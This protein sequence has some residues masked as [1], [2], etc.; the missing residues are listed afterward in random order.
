MKKFILLFFGLGLMLAQETHAQ[1]PMSTIVKLQNDKEVIIRSIKKHERKR[2]AEKFDSRFENEQI[3]QVFYLAIQEFLKREDEQ[4]ELQFIDF[5]KKRFKTIGIINNE[6]EIQDIFK[7]L[8]ITNAIDDIFYDILSGLNKDHQKLGVLKLDKKNR[9]RSAKHSKL[10]QANNLKDLFSG[11]SEWP[12]ESS[13]CV[14][15]EFVFIKNSIKNK[16]GKDSDKKRHLKILLEKAYQEKVFD[17]ATFNKLEYLRTESFVTKRNYWLKDYFK[18]IFN[19]KNKMRPLKATYVV[20][21]IEDEEGY[22]TE[23][24]RRFSRMTRRQL[25]YKKYDET[26]IILLAQVLQ[27]ASRRM[28]VDPDTE[29]GKP[30]ITQ[31]FHTL[32]DAGTR[33]TY[34]E[35][36]ELDPQSQYNLARR[37]LRKDMT[38]LQMMDTFIGL[39]V[40]YEDL[41]MAAF[42]TGYITFEDLEF[43][44]KYDDLW[45]P[46]KSS[47]EKIIGFTFSVA[48][49]SSIFLPPPWNITATIAL[50]VIEGLILNTKRD[51]AENDNP[52]TFIE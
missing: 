27:K 11:F 5:I 37:L 44:V 30:V 23:R 7:M 28:G 39:K 26:Q 10:L 18:I 41:V 4:C 46:N 20:K 49:V 29:S 38:E 3:T 47:F 13:R 19:A 36:I 21:N 16:D 1:I 6:E 24:I 9:K 33:D 35:R 42:E 31:E 34:V 43:V 48:G 51:G 22:S 8:R 40:T 25:L 45:N 52:A 14:Y 17:L 15:Q 50:G 12:D 32:N 2:I